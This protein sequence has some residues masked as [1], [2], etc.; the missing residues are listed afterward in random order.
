MMPAMM[1]E[2]FQLSRVTCVHSIVQY[3]AQQELMI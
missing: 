2:S 3:L 1:H